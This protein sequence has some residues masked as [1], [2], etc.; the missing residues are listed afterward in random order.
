MVLLFARRVPAPGRGAEFRF[1]CSL[2]ALRSPPRP[3]VQRTPIRFF[4][5]VPRLLALFAPGSGTR[6]ILGPEPD[7]DPADPT[8]PPSPLF[9]SF[10]AR[11]FRSRSRGG[12]IYRLTSLTYGQRPGSRFRSPRVD[13][14]PTR[15]ASPDPHTAQRQTQ[16]PRSTPCGRHRDDR[17]SPIKT[18]DL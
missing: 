11:F 7:A 2:S 10:L 15:H 3:R 6:K 4:C 9:F 5:V 8:P 16:T 1:C 18:R 14:K 12:Y 17:A 13:P